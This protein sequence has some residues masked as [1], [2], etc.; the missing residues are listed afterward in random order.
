MKKRLQ[1]YIHIP[2]C[3]HHC[4]YCT[5]CVLT[6]GNAAKDDYMRALEKELAAA[7]PVLAEYTI[8]SIYLGGGSPTVMSPDAVG[9]LVRKLQEGL[10]IERPMEI[11]IE[12]MP[13]TIGTPSLSGL[14]LGHFTRYSL[15][16]QSAVPEELE[17]LDCGFT[18]QQVDTALLF[19][20]KFK[21][22][23]IN[24]DV[25]VGLPGQ[26]HASWQHTLEALRYFNVAHV[27]IYPFPGATDTATATGV[28]TGVVGGAAIGA[29][30]ATADSRL[31]LELQEQAQGFL[32][33]LGYRRY[34]L[35]H[36]ARPGFEC[37]HFIDR[38]SGI[39]Y[40]GFGLGARS[41]VDG[42][43][44]S[45]TAD[46][47]TYIADSADFEHIVTNVV[48]LTPEQQEEYRSQSRSFLMG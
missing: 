9:N 41:L 40:M 22:Q 5:A 44:Y 8:A 34:S 11:S 12:A 30:D 47:D 26:D 19:L 13:Q 37:R 16:M 32:E 1:V 15:S 42:I 38:F 4:R 43:S 20:D 17:A 23:N 7:K 21:H 36:Y 14:N 18:I 28:A 48:E 31:I 6:G 27:S 39:D 35:Y 24:L 3:I 46:W 2:F 45:N 33:G 29:N 25:M 10:D